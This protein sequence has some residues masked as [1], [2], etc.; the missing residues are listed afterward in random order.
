MESPGL[1]TGLS[2][3]GQLGLSINPEREK[4]GCYLLGCCWELTPGSGPS[5]S[6]AN[7]ELG[8]ATGEEEET[9]RCFPDT[10]V[11]FHP[12]SPNVCPQHGEQ[13]PSD[14]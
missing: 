12:A 8:E 4:Q 11:A 2:E 6:A 1:Q 10:R 5:G 7:G 9:A 14:A 13:S 3:Q